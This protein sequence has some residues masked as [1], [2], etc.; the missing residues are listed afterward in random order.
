MVWIA[1]VLRGWLKFDVVNQHTGFGFFHHKVDVVAF[2]IGHAVILRLVYHFAALAIL[3]HVNGQV[4]KRR[5][6]NGVFRE[7]RHADGLKTAQTFGGHTNVAC[8]LGFG[9]GSACAVDQGKV[10]VVQCAL[11]DDDNKVGAVLELLWLIRFVIV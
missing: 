2:V 6:Q 1:A 10:F 9:G 8:G 5:D 3:V 7:I 11:V 4:R